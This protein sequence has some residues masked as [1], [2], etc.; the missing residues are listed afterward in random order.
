VDVLAD[1]C[2]RDP[3]LILAVEV[4]EHLQSPW[5]FLAACRRL[6]SNRTQLIVT[7]PNVGSW[8]SRLWFLLTGEPWGFSPESWTD[9]GHIHPLTETEMRGLLSAN[10]FACKSVSLAGNLPIIWAYNWKRLLASLLMLP[11][12]PL[13]RGEK[14]GWVLCYHATVAS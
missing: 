5:H 9:P 10:G 1:A 6:S 13:M 12:R 8:W 3:D 11:L 2:G 7:T 4:I 14:D